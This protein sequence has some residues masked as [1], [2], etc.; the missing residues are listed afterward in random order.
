VHR[1][2]HPI[3]IHRT[4]WRALLSRRSRRVRRSALDKKN[5]CSQNQGNWDFFLDGAIFPEVAR[6][7]ARPAAS[8]EI[9]AAKKYIMSTDG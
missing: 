2:E 5:R 9:K 7:K 6:V 3:D 8:F 4:R 1:P